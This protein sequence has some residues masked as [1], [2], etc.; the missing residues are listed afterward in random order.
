MHKYNFIKQSGIKECGV[1]CISMIIKHYGGFINHYRLVELTK[2]NKCGTNAYN[3]VSA[4]KELGFTSYGIRYD[5]NKDEPTINLPAIAHTVIDKSYNHFVLIY[6]INFKKRFLII[7]D[8]ASKIKKMTFD[9]FNQIFTNVLIIAYPNR[10]IEKE[11]HIKFNNYLKKYIK[12]NQIIPS[13]LLIIISFIIS[14]IYLI[15]IK[16]ILN[17]NSINCTFI[18]LPILV[19]KYIINNLK[20]KYILALKNKTNQELMEESFIDILKLPYSFYRNH[21]TGEIVSRLNDIENIKDFVDVFVVL[22]SD[23]IIILTS[24]TILLLINKTLF[25]VTLFIMILYFLNYL[26][27]NKKITSS[28]QNLKQSKAIL[29]SFETEAIVGFESVKGQNLKDYFDNSFKLK[30][31][32]YLN[33]LETYQTIINKVNNINSTI[34]DLSLYLIIIFGLILINQNKLE[35]SNLLIFYTLSNYFINPIFDISSL[36]ILINEIKISLNRLLDLKYEIKDTKKYCYGDIEIKNLSF[37][38]EEK[39]ILSNLNMN[40]KK[41]ENIVITGES[42][43]GKSTLLKILKQY[44]KTDN[45]YI[46]KEKI[47]KLNL[48]DNITYISQDEYLFTDTLYNNI[49]L[50]K[51]VK[52]E[53]LDKII[54]ICN[55]DHL[56]N[57]KLGLNMLIEENGF[58]LSGGEKERIILARSLINIKDYLFIDEGLSEVDVNMERSIL[59]SIIDEYKEKTIIFVTHRNNNI[60]LFDKMINLNK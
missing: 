4:L 49:T 38:K 29:N 21:T 32:I 51:S 18:I 13:L 28:L 46:N 9:E 31:K 40:I 36:F 23:I 1:A 33:N 15:F 25:I 54:K 2:T 26:F 24:G 50:N 35:Y 34:N 53:D 14:I 52:K 12:F 8:P 30:S 44:Y 19:L 48:K 45:V 39:L 43:C 27:H 22:L 58:N 47:N 3:I 10:K 17:K 6:E 16:N 5:L 42:G 60:D 20:N 41:G 37:S 56:A 59:K 11:K 57:N 55:L 7:A